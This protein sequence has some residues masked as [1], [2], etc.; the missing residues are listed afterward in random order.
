MKK[1]VELAIISCGSQ[2]RFSPTTTIFDSN[3]VLFF[4][5]KTL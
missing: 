1:E 5:F 3:Y 4:V 2:E